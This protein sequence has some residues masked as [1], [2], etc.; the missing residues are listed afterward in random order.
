LKDITLGE[1]AVGLAFIVALIASVKSLRKDIKTWIKEVM[2]EE[3]APLKKSVEETDLE[4]CKNYLV[5]FLSELERGEPK[6]EIEYQRFWEQYERYTKKGGNTYVMHR[7]EM[8]KSI[9]KL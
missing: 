1:I 5:T 8:L 6:D 9:N 3:I 7:V 4:N 2:K